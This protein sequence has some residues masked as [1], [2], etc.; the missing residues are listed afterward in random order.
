[1]GTVMWPP[2]QSWYRILLAY[3]KAPSWSFVLSAILPLDPG[4]PWS[5]FS[6]ISCNWNYTIY[7]LLFWP[8]LLSIMLL[9]L[10]YIV[11]LQHS[12]FLFYHWVLLHC[13]HIR[14]FV[15]CSP[16][17]SGLS[18]WG[19]YESSCFKHS[20]TNL[21]EHKL[22]FLLDKYLTG[23]SESFEK[24]F[25]VLFFKWKTAK[26]FYKMVV[27]FCILNQ[28]CMRILLVQCPH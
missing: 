2:P 26:L 7:N 28:Q 27:P 16:V 18:I 17:P 12:F 11:N 4:S 9:R 24:Y 6:R 15:Y 22:L 1:M 5:A 25:L 13:M 20:S 14:H 10:R 8:L 3:Q 23:I 21:C 19:Y